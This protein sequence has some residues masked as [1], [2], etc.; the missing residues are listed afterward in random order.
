MRYNFD[1]NEL[2]NNRNALKN[3]YNNSNIEDKNEIRITIDMYNHMLGLANRK[4]NVYDKFDDTLKSTD[5]NQLVNEFYSFYNKNTLPIINMILPA[6]NTLKSF[7]PELLNIFGTAD[8]NDDWITITLEFFKRMTTP[9]IYNQVK[10]L[11]EK[12]KHFLNINYYKEYYA[13]PAATLIDGILKKKYIVLS[14]NNEVLDYPNLALELFHYLF[15]DYDTKTLTEHN[16][17]FL[18]EVE[19]MFA[20][21]LFSEYFNYCFQNENDTDPDL[22]K[23]FFLLEF[24]SQVSELVIRNGLLDSL[25]KNKKIR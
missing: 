15:S 12:N 4:N 23:K 10:E 19:G 18:S 6:I 13:Y 16:S 1:F 21:I 24:K 3:L 2:R 14:K 20:N 8:T 11:F 5:I 7:N 9:H 17:F 25:D 22:M